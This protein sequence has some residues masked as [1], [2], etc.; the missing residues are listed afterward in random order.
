MKD[1]DKI[2]SEKLYNHKTPPP[3]SLWDQLDDA[4]EAEQRQNKK[5]FWWRIAA[6]IIL[7][8]IAS[9]LFWL[10]MEQDEG[11]KVAETHQA[12]EL[13][14]EQPE[15]A[16]EEIDPLAK[17][18]APAP[19]LPDSRV[20]QSLEKT[21]KPSKGEKMHG[22]QEAVSQEK[23]PYLA[24]AHN[25]SAKSDAVEKS[26]IHE[27]EPLTPEPVK[28]ES[29][30]LANLETEFTN[31]PGAVTIIYKPGQ[32]TT[33]N[34]D[35][36]DLSKPMELLADLKNSKI[37]VSEIRNAKSDLLAKVFNKIDNEFSR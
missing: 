10:Q 32:K 2:F 35:Q 4:L 33:A 28:L 7:L 30:Q 23:E 34:V 19:T 24:E 8:M 11:E 20:K 29:Q 21:V 25:S 31:S 6:A 26:A 12:P 15:I 9:S 13:P 16:P 1:F 22:S 3:A 17:A 37:T 18:P 36:T 27:I 5:V 14:K